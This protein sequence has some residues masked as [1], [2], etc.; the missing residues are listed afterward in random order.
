MCGIAGAIGHPSENVIKGM[1]ERIQHRGPDASG[2]KILDDVSIGNVRLSIIDVD[3]GDQPLSDSDDHQWLVYNGELYGYQEIRSQCTK[4]GHHFKTASDTEII[5]PLYQKYG[6]NLFDK[7]NGMFAF[8]LYDRDNEALILARDHFGI[9]PLVYTII[10]QRLYFASEVKAFYAIPTWTALPDQDA[11]HTFFNIRFPPAPKTLFKDVLKIP[12]GCYLFLK[13]G[14]NRKNGSRP[15]IPLSHEYIASINLGEWR[16]AIYRYYRLPSR[17]SSIAFQDARQHLKHLFQ[18]AINDQMI[19][20]VPLG[21]YLSGGIDSSTVAAFAS[22]FG[23][24]K[25][26]TFCMGFGEPT[27]EN[28]DANTIAEKFGT[29]HK[30]LILDENPLDYYRRA[31]F[32]M[33][34]PKVNCLQGFLLAREAV[35]QQK[36]ILSGLGGDELFGGYDVYELALIFDFLKKSSLP[37]RLN[38]IGKVLKRLLRIN[39]SLR[40]DLYRRGADS[41]S[42]ISDPLNLYLLLRNGWDH[43]FMLVKHIYQDGVYENNI[44]P[45]R[46]HFK[47]IFPDRYSLVDAFMRFEFENKMVDDFLMNEDR[48]SMAHSLEVRVPFLDRKIVEFG[49][50]LPAEWKIRFRRRKIII[51]SML[52]GSLPPSIINKRK[53]GFTFNPV[54][55]A[56][57]DLMSL[58]RL[59][60]TRKRVEESNLFN[61][62]YLERIMQSRPHPNLRWHYFLLWKILGYFIWEDLFIKGKRS[63][64]ER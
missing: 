46:E 60:L 43:D 39:P 21:V 33:E 61:F 13:R 37:F 1:L 41:I 2:Y 32:F 35:K 49:F 27:D 15:K 56:R 62:N 63:A 3:G 28:Q 64:F 23:K 10:N 51:K 22:R 9:K 5:F 34:E 40:S 50:S 20:D 36:V 44:A 8:C 47:K 24:L 48:M 57:K 53:H 38:K 25:I 14:S 26:N 7:L 42:A 6:L 16:G 17:H 12:P 55:Q 29:T 54:I 52:T 58:A 45:V 18:K 19:A 30:D 4:E 11:W 31:I 59:Y